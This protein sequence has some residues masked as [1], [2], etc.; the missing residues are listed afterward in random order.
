MKSQACN[1]VKRVG[2]RQLANPSRTP[3]RPG[4]LRVT[5]SNPCQAKREVDRGATGESPGHSPTRH[6]DGMQGVRGSNPLS[7][8]TTTPQVNRHVVPGLSTPPPPLIRAWGTPGAWRPAPPSAA[9]RSR[10]PP[11]LASPRS[12][13]GSGDRMAGCTAAAS[14]AR[15]TP[16]SG[17][18][19][20][21]LRKWRPR[22]RPG[23]G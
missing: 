13:A 2:A 23:T 20:A 6:I 18:G 19:T 11:G 22:C 5:R 8:T 10:R 4:K 9:R 17:R 15:T 7:S 16:S 1:S 14:P 12:C 3:I 21:T